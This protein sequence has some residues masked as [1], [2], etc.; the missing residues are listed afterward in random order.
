MG[1]HIEND[2][3]S[4]G[5][6]NRRDSLLWTDNED[7][8]AELEFTLHTLLGLRIISVKTFDEADK[9]LREKQISIVLSDVKINYSK[10]WKLCQEIKSNEQ[11]RHIPVIMLLDQTDKKNRTAAL[12]WGADDF[13][14]RPFDNSDIYNR[15]RAQM[16]IYELHTMVVNAEREKVMLE[17]AGAAAHELAQPITSA[18]GL[19][20]IILIKNEQND[21]KIEFSKEMNMLYECLQ[22]M[23][24]VIHKIQRIRKYETTPY[25]G[26]K[27]IID[28]TKASGG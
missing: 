14:L 11:M 27:S 24:E 20:Q 8:A 7:E 1:G 2:A 15:I 9:V 17:M 28:I 23:T 18:M 21:Q 10:P 13:I 3:R 26:A 16:R 5:F 4:S 19:I 22:R 12:D 6:Y 25:A